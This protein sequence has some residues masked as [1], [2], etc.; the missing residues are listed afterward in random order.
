[1]KECFY[2]F[3]DHFDH[4]LDNHV[5]RKCFD[6]PPC[7]TQITAKKKVATTRFKSPVRPS[8]PELRSSGMRETQNASGKTLPFNK[9]EATTVYPLPKQIEKK[10]NQCG[11]TDHTWNISIM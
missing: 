4:K 9:Y 7:V 5:C 3:C 1:M 2:A 6:N 10:C 11:G 8:A